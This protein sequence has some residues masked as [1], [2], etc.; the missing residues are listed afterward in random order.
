MGTA[1]M[2]C[3]VIISQRTIDSSELDNVDDDSYIGW[4]LRF[5]HLFIAVIGTSEEEEEEEVVVSSAFVN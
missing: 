1:G 5:L 3:L 4:H 2:I